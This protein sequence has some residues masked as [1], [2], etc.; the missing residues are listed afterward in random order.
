[1]FLSGKAGRWHSSSNEN[2]FALRFATVLFVCFI[3]FVCVFVLVKETRFKT[4]NIW[5]SAT[6]EI[7]TLVRNTRSTIGV[8]CDPYTQRKSQAFR[9]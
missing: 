5:M 6:R 2:L 8:L 7:L 3:L 1:M 9:F 4:A